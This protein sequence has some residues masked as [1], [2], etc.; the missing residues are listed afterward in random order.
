M[1]DINVKIHPSSNLSVNFDEHTDIAIGVHPSALL[2]VNVPS[3][4][5]GGD[6][7]NN[8][9]FDGSDGWIP[10]VGWTIS[11]GTANCDGT[12]GNNFLVNDPNPLTSG[13]TYRVEFTV[14]EYNSGTIRYR[15]GGTS[16]T[17]R[18]STGTFVQSGVSD[19]VNFRMQGVAFDGKIDNIRA[20]IY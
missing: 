14:V 15:L 13:E 19:N 17:V 3:D 1:A 8:G 10:I 12:P 11:G 7:I 2:S 18:S 20:Y 16:G 9:N 6:V 5:E 4:V